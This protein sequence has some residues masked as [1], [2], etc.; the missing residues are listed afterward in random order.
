MNDVALNF[1]AEFQNIPVKGFKRFS[2]AITAKTN[3]YD[4]FNLRL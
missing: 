3:L 1:I 4:D 2:L